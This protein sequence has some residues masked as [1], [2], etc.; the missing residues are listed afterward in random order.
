M[1]GTASVALP[2]AVLTDM[3]SLEDDRLKRM[4][5]NKKRL[6]ELRLR[7]HK[8]EMIKQVSVAGHA[9]AHM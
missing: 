7:E 5:E 8:D 3:S 6:A 9:I 2:G 4:E 1:S